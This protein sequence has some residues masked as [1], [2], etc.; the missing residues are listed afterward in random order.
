MKKIKYLLAVM[1]LGCST[2]SFAQFMNSGS[3]RSSSSSS[4]SDVEAW[5]GLRISY[6]RMFMN[7][8]D[9]TYGDDFWKDYNGFSVSY[10][11]SFKIAPKLPIFFETGLGVNFGRFKFTDWQDIDDVDYSSTFLGLTIPLNFVYGAKINDKVS[12]KPYTGFFLRVNV[13]GKGKLSSSDDDIQDLLEDWEM[14]SVN[15]FD[16]DDM[17]DDDYTWKRCQFGWQI[18]TT[19][20][21]NNFNIGI[22]YA[23]DFNNLAE[24]LKTSK[25]SINLG[26]NF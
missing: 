6:D 13:L 2:M 19:F 16:E 22:N 26:F 7:Y 18:G 15:Y 4:S 9:D 8:D 10:V 12:V 20:D 24:D 23:L 25:F 21:I 3:G 17:G 1:L 14:T 11:Q 5:K